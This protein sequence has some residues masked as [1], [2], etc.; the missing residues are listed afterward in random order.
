MGPTLQA[1]AE[2]PG[3][4]STEPGRLRNSGSVS[5]HPTEKGEQAVKYHRSFPR[6]SYR[7]S[8]A[9]R[10][11]GGAQGR[12]SG[13]SVVPT[14]IRTPNSELL[15]RNQGVFVIAQIARCS[16]LIFWG[17]SHHTCSPDEQTEAMTGPEPRGDLV[18]ELRLDPSL[19]PRPTASPSQGSPFLILLSE[20]HCDRS[21]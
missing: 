14:L 2:S 15:H 11:A 6:R 10:G 20:C 3:C 5:A 1:P 21:L 16:G 8:G 4:G 17:G 19:L 7:G 9:P 18:V 12:L 13:C